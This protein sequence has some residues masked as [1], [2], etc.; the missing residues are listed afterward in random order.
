MKKITARSVAFF[1][2]DFFYVVTQSIGMLSYPEPSADPHFLPPDVD[3]ATLGRTLRLALSL[4]RSVDSE[5]FQRL[6]K[7]GDIQKIENSREAWAMNEYGYKTKR[8]MRR[9]MNC[10]WISVSEGE[11]QV[12]PTHHKSLDTY[13]GISNDGPEILHVPELAS[14]AELGA[15]LREGFRRCTSAVK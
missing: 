1:N 10:C 11:V 8:A 14:D 7:S 2:G 4:S 6:W 12:K 5:E 13:T 3:D 9:N 15:A